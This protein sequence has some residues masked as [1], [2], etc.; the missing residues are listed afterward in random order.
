MDG[1]F[2][3]LKPYAQKGYMGKTKPWT[4]QGFRVLPV[5]AIVDDRNHRYYPD[6]D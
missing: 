2:R 6:E 5:T 1:G 4:G 3:Y